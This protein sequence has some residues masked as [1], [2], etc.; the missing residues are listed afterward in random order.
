MLLQIVHCDSKS[1]NKPSAVGGV[2]DLSDNP[3]EEKGIVS[4]DGEWEFYWHTLLTPDDFRNANPLENR[5]Y[6]FLP[7]AW[8]KSVVDGQTLNGNGYATFRL[9]INHSGNE[10]LALKVPRIFTSYKLWVNGNLLAHAGETATTQQEM[11]P[12]YLP[13][14]AVFNAQT[15]TIEIIVQAANYRH[16]S[17]GMLESIQIGPATQIIDMRTR[18]LALELF[19][20]G[21]LFIIGFYHIALYVFRTKDPSSLYFG[22]YALL[23]SARTLVVGEIFLIYLLPGFNWEIAHKI[24]TLAFYA[25]VPLVVLF[26]ESIFPLDTVPKVNKAVYIVGAGFSSLVLL[27]PARI[28]TLVNPIYQLLTV[29]TMIYV[30]YI[31]AAAIYHKREGSLLIGAGVFI[32][33]IFSLN[34]ILFL[35]I[36][37]ADTDNHALRN[38]I[39]RGDLT[40]FGLLLFTLM[41]SL[42]LARKFSNSFGKVELL[43]QQL[44]Q[45][46]VGLEEKVK[47]RTLELENSKQELQKAYKA[48]SRSEKSLQQLMQNISHDLRT[49]LSSIKGYTK[50]ILDGIVKES[51]Q[52]KV[53][54]RILD[55]VNQLNNMVQDLFDLSQLETRQLEF[56]LSRMPVHAFIRSISEKYSLDMRNESITFKVN[57]LPD[58]ATVKTWD[59]YVSIDL[60]RLERVFA[61]LLSNALKFTP[62]DGI[63]VL[64]IC[65]TDEKKSLLIDISDTGAGISEEHQHH[66]FER[67]YKVSKSRHGGSTNSTGLGLSIVKEIVEYHGGKVWVES[68]LGKGSHF[69]FTIPLYT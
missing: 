25:G 68:Q 26:L 46:N 45:T 54:H 9:I 27:T 60:Q 12:Q 11:I 39:L 18:N 53:I 35:S 51:E 24:Q 20:F 15:E 65:F 6:I 13:Q 34:D 31:V 58:I 64:S 48:V 55:K 66:I 32:L 41:Q 37:L 3:L 14:V 49:P 57:C 4:L 42:V 8:N 52:H 62:P 30:L 22:I 21:S 67:F 17:G 10:V 16:R 38:F 28:F 23:I 40:S 44:R 36:L 63:I 43:T 59:F 33:V 50:A 5:Q 69:Y 47:E 1:E 7:R 29:S 2:L 19:L 56:Q 61:N